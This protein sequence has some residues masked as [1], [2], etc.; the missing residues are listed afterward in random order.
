MDRR[1]LVGTGPRVSAVDAK[2]VGLWFGTS[3]MLEEER[4]NPEKVAASEDVSRINLRSS[5]Y[6]SLTLRP[7]ESVSWTTTA[8][9][10]PRFDAFD[11]YRIAVESGLALKVAKRLAFTVDA[12]YRNDSQPPI[13]PDGS[14]PVL[15]TDFNV[16]NGLK[17]TF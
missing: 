11:D 7:S 17:I 8:Y 13:T 4:L 12:R 1:L 6:A 2:R 15:A 10:Q 3:A 16:K 9:F 14:A 5:T